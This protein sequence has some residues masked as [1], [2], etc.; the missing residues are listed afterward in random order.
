ASKSSNMSLLSISEIARQAGLRPSAIRY[1][2]QRRILPPARRMSGQR[3]YEMGAVDQLSVLPRGP[4]AGFSP[5]E[6]RRLFTG[7]RRSTPVSARW[8]KIAARK[9]AE[10]DLEIQRIQSMKDLLT[11]L[12]SG[13]RCET[14]SECGAKILEARRKFSCAS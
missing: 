7:F 6:I 8:Q 11:R 14:V 4:G 2:E 5:D 1:Y 13:C 9:Q 3:R 10:L 12:Q